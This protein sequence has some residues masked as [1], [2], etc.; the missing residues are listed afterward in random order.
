MRSR[1]LLTL[2]AAAGLL[3]AVGAPLASA[4]GAR[5]ATASFIDATGAPVGWARWSRT[6][7]A[8]ST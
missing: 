2:A 1:F 5:H 6:L 7:A 4:D 8:S 3:L